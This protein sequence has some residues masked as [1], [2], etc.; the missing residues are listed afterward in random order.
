MKIVIELNTDDYIEISGW[1]AVC[2]LTGE[3][4]GNNENNSYGPYWISGVLEEL[5]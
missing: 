2:G 5:L 3:M 1:V 4:L